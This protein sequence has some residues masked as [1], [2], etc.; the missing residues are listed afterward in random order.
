[1]TTLFVLF[2]SIVIVISINIWKHN[3]HELLEHAMR[4]YAESAKYLSKAIRES[5]N[6][7]IREELEQNHLTMECLGESCSVDNG[8]V[9]IKTIKNGSDTISIFRS[10][11]DKIGMLIK[12]DGHMAFMTKKEYESDKHFR[13][14]LVLIGLTSLMCMLYILALLNLSKTKKIEEMLMLKEEFLCAVSHEIKT[15]L[16]KAKLALEF[17]PDGDKKE[18]VR[19]AVR[20]ID[21]LS[22]TLLNAQR[23]GL[24]SKQAVNAGQLVALSLESAAIDKNIE[25]KVVKDFE[26]VCDIDACVIAI[27]NLIENGIKHSGDSSC[28][29]VVDDTAISVRSKGNKI[30]KSIEELSRAFVK[31]ENSSGFGLGL[32][33]VQ[34]IAYRNGLKFTLKRENEENIFS[35]ELG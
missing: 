25:V 22:S 32:Y 1:M 33:L 35:L 10:D 30:N 12:T 11:N 31:S 6:E 2:F 5:K 23:Y 28:T 19:G 13:D 29:I 16:A 4:A 20:Q 21:T 3:E 15:P 8:F 26:I 17:M 18:L 14:L 27:K 24:S 9:L 34:N 7:D